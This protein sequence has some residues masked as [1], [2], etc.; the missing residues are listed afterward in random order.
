M[1]V[2]DLDLVRDVARDVAHAVRNLESP[3]NAR[4][5][6]ET[7]LRPLV[8][9]HEDLFSRS[10]QRA[11]A[12]EFSRILYFDPGL[13][14]QL[15]KFE[16]GF[17]LPVHNHEAWNAL[18]LCAG[19]MQFCGYRRLD[20]RSEPGRARLEI[21]DERILGAG[22]VGIVAPPPH[23]IHELEVLTD[24]TWLVTVTPRPEVEVREIYDPAEGSYEINSLVALPRRL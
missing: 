17:R 9:P 1:A 24:D 11:T 21:H 15:S 6:V 5:A 18:F 7:A 10:M 12:L 23:D 20:D 14:F 22:D 4:G 8:G 16:A 2:V 3:K 13:M 19:R